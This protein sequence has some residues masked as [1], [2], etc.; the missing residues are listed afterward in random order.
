MESRGQRSEDHVAVTMIQVGDSV[1]L[2]YGGSCVLE[3]AWVCLVAH[4]L[5]HPSTHVC[6]VPESRCWRC[7]G[8]PAD[9]DHG[10]SE[11]LRSIS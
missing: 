10:R 8:D 11:T 1:G 4:F 3:R 7:S 5:I 9:G 6:G 2:N